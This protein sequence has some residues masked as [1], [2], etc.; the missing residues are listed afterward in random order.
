MAPRNARTAIAQEPAAAGHNSGLLSWTDDQ[1]I[2]K[3]QQATLE[4]IEAKVDG[5]IAAAEKS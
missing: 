5:R 4:R 3:N 2:A 1:L